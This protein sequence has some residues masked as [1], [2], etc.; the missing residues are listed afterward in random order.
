MPLPSESLSSHPRTEVPNKDAFEMSMDS[1]IRLGSPKSFDSFLFVCAIPR[2]QVRSRWLLTTA[3]RSSLKQAFCPP[4]VRDE[5]DGD[6][7][8]SRARRSILPDLENIYFL[9]RRGIHLLGRRFVLRAFDTDPHPDYN[10]AFACP[11]VTTL[12]CTTWVATVCF[13]PDAL[14]EPSVSVRD[15]KRVLY[16]GRM[17]PLEPRHAGSVE[18]VGGSGRSSPGKS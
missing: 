17:H 6:R 18:G 10:F 2:T 7:L 15:M 3:L 5:F 14:P 11:S 1:R 8:R 16:R 4:R 12:V 13:H 9:P